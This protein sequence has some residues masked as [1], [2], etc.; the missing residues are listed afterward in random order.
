M[1]VGTVSSVD[2]DVW[3]LIATNTPSA[4]TSSTFSSV[5]GYKKLM[6]T[7]QIPTLSSASIIYLRFNSDSTT[8]NYAGVTALYTTAGG[9]RDNTRLPISGYSETEAYGYAVIADTNKTTPKRI[10]DM[11]GMQIGYGNGIYFGTSEIS[12]VLVFTNTTETMTGTIKLY[13]VAA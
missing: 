12:S 8:G 4:V 6:I 1:A 9:T 5:S 3:Q 11:G 10:E 2:G 7:Y 13:G